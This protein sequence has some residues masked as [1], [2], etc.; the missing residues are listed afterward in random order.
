MQDVRVTCVSAAARAS[1]L[2]ALCK[3]VDGVDWGNGTLT[4]MAFESLDDE[5]GVRIFGRWRSRAEM[6]RFVRR[7]DVVAFW[8]ENKEFV[9][10]MDQRLYVPN[11]KGWLHR[12]SGYAG[13]QSGGEKAKI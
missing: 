12:G 6:E 11:G 2:T 5:L 4:Y 3:M 13:E 8:M 10:G 1:L 7:E 9:K